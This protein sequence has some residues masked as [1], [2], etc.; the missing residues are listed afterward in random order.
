MEQVWKDMSALDQTN[1]MMAIVT[2]LNEAPRPKYWGTGQNII[3]IG[4]V[5][6]SYEV[7]VAVYNQGAV[8]APRFYSTTT[9]RHINKVAARWRAPVVQMWK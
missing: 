4:D 7:P 9:S 3:T 2:T 1:H 8:W 5:I 6:Y